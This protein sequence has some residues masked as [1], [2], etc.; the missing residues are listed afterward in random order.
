MR[1][2]R[3]VAPATMKETLLRWALW[4]RVVIGGI[5][6]AVILIA[7]PLAYVLRFNFT[8]IFLD[9]E[10]WRQF[11]AG[12]VVLVPI[13]FL[14]RYVF[15]LH[16][17]VWRHTSLW[18]LRRLVIA[19][20]IGSLVGVS[21][22]AFISRLQG[23]PRSVFILEWGIY[24]F[25]TAGVRITSRMSWEMWRG[26]RVGGGPQ[27]MKSVIVIGAGSAG[28]TLVRALAQNPGLGECVVAV[29]DDDQGKHNRELHG[30]P[31]LTPVERLPELLSDFETRYVYIALPSATSAQMRRIV[32]ICEE[33][34]AEF[35]TLPSISDTLTGRA[36]LSQL[37]PVQL[38]DLLGRE[39]VGIDIE[40]IADW[41]QG[42]RILVTGAA[43]SI[44]SE[45]CRQLLGFGIDHLTLLDQ[46]ELH[47]YLLQ[48]ELGPL[49]AKAPHRCVIGSITDQTLV[50]DLLQSEGPQVI[51][52]AAAYKHVHLMEENPRAALVTNVLGTSI[53]GEAARRA[54]VEHF[55]LI[56]SDKA[57]H[58]TSVMGA[59]KRLA[60]QLC[61]GFDDRGPTAFHVVRF[62]NVIGS[63]GSVVPLFERQLAAGGPLT[64][65]HREVTRFFMTIP[66][67]V[68]L[69]LQAVVMGQGGEIFLLE[70][71]EPIK[72]LDLAEQLIRLAGREPHTDVPIQF[73]GLRPGEKLREELW[74]ADEQKERT[75]H[76]KILKALSSATICRPELLLDEVDRLLSSSSTSLNR[77]II[78]LANDGIEGSDDDLSRKSRGAKVLPLNPA[79]RGRGSPE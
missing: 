19:S 1:Q 44:G 62:G 20:A 60:E 21:A 63:S 18:E 25:L 58:P 69:I 59:T 52:H 47:L 43:G 15:R 7:L 64:V 70:M 8:I 68:R 66:E 46:S 79:G 22:V 67:A 76:P 11:L 61:L 57:V 5:D 23:M 35:R 38:E 12:F 3:V 14:L 45:L 53:V 33:A 39:P 73:I 32:R 48:D 78:D 16:R 71:G 36:I 24:L 9:G 75:A 74:H 77:A 34:D 40:G 72:I 56:S 65:T 42:K 54:G 4:R 17:M 29:L 13:R 28:S 6:F 31:I 50:S 55:V 51:F 10:Y 27:Q 41:L 26:R 30:V 37:R 2:E 49:L